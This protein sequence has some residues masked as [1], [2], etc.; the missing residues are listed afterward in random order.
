M[1]PS[2]GARPRGRWIWR[3]SL[4]SAAGALLFLVVV[5]GFNTALDATNSLD[6]CVSCHTMRT[7][8][9]EYKKTTHYSNRSGV[10][11]TCSD[12]HVAK[13]DWFAEMRRKFEAADDVWGEITGVIDTKEKFDA[14]RLKMAEAEWARMK[15]S[16]SIGCRNCHSFASMDLDQQDKSASNKHRRAA[17]P[18]SG[19]T[20]IDCHK[21]IAHDLPKAS[22]GDDRP[23]SSG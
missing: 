8:F 2:A 19:K 23:V 21:G 9:E 7:N 18:G 3:I 20:C 12:C 11:A 1:N 13:K 5:G 15:E 4:G 10:R 16:D 22:E 14:R 17:M 6:F